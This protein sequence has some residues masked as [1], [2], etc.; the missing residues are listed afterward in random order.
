[1][2][3]YLKRNSHHH[4]PVLIY[5][6][7]ISSR[8]IISLSTPA[9]SNLSGQN[10]IKWKSVQIFEQKRKL[11]NQTEEA[12]KPTSKKA[13]V[14]NLKIEEKPININ[15]SMNLFQDNPKSILGPP[16]SPFSIFL[17]KLPRNPPVK[18]LLIVL[19]NESCNPR[20][21]LCHQGCWNA[22]LRHKTNWRSN[23][24]GCSN[25]GCLSLGTRYVV[26]V[27]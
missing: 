24:M 22:G 11:T 25:H 9:L 14:S 15:R 18:N 3:C 5:P 1:M 4:T 6:W 7:F 8:G 17:P 21:Y 10:M 20:P 16:M 26:D 19:M 13:E 12:T 23:P 2:L 27:L